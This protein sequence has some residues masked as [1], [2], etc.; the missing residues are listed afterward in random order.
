MQRLA[1]D[2][3][4]GKIAGNTALSNRSQR[5]RDR[6]WGSSRD[7]V[8]LASDG[9]DAGSPRDGRVAVATSPP[10]AMTRKGVKP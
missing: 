9:M 5:R 2:A 3:E 4:A 1:R 6:G 8:S 7:V 10:K